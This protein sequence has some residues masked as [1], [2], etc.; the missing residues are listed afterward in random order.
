VAYRGKI[1]ALAA[2]PDK[3]GLA[4]QLGVDADVLDDTQRRGEILAWIE[5][6]VLGNR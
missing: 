1:A 4:W 5:A 3:A 2:N 6:K